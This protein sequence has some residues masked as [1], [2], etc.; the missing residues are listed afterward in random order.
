[1]LDA[2]QGTHITDFIYGLS[3]AGGR[4]LLLF[5]TAGDMLDSY[6]FNS[7]VVDGW[8][9][10]EFVFVVTADDLI[11]SLYRGK[12]TLADALYGEP[13]V[14][15]N[16]VSVDSVVSG[17]KRQLEALSSS[18]L[19]TNK[20]TVAE[21]ELLDSKSRVVLPEDQAVRVLH[22]VP[23][24]V[25]IDIE[26]PR[27]ARGRRRFLT[28]ASLGM[29]LVRSLT[30]ADQDLVYLVWSGTSSRQVHFQRST[31]LNL[32]RVIDVSGQI[33]TINEAV[34]FSSLGKLCLAGSRNGMWEVLLVRTATLATE[35]LYNAYHSKLADCGECTAT[36]SVAQDGLDTYF[37]VRIP[38]GLRLIKANLM[39]NAVVQYDTLRNQVSNDITV[40]AMMLD[41]L[42][43]AGLLFAHLSEDE[44]TVAYKFQMSDLLIFG[45]NKFLTT[46]TAVERVIS[47]TADTS[48]R[49]LFCLTSV[50]TIQVKVVKLNLFALHAFEPTVADTRGGSLIT[51][52]GEGFV[53]LGQT[54]C[55]FGDGISAYVEK[56]V[57]NT[58]SEIICRAPED[59]GGAN[60]CTGQLLEVTL[61]GGSTCTTDSP[62]FSQNALRLLRVPTSTVIT[63]SPSFNVFQ[64][65]TVVTLEGIGFVDSNYLSC[66]WFS[67]ATPSDPPD[68]DAIYAR[69]DQNH[70]L[71]PASSRHSVTYVNSFKI[72]CKQ[73]P[74]TNNQPTSIPAYVE[75]S[76]DGQLYSESQ[77]E[78]AIYGRPAGLQ[79]RE[80][81]VSVRADLESDVEAMTIVTVDEAGHE[82]LRYDQ[83]DARN[84][85]EREVFMRIAN[86]RVDDNSN[87]ASTIT[88]EGDSRRSMTSG[89]VQ[90][91]NIT[92]LRP[93][94]GT[95]DAVFTHIIRG[96]TFNATTALWDS[97]IV[98]EWSVTV[99]ITV[100]SGTAVTLSIAKQPSNESNHA[101]DLPL[102]V[103]PELEFLDSAENVVTNPETSTIGVVAEWQAY[104]WRPLSSNKT[105]NSDSTCPNGR[106]G[107]CTCKPEYLRALNYSWVPSDAEVCYNAV[108][109]SGAQPSFMDKYGK[110]IF[111]DVKLVGFH[112][113]LYKLKFRVT[114]PA[115]LGDTIRPVESHYIHVGRCSPQSTTYAL[116][117][118]EVCKACPNDAICSGTIHIQGK[119][120]FWRATNLTT[121]FY[122]CSGSNCNASV[123]C[124]VSTCPNAC[125]EGYRGV[126]CSVC[127]K[128]YGRSGDT[129][130]PCPK[131]EAVCQP[132]PKKNRSGAYLF[133]RTYG[134]TVDSGL[135][136]D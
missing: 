82:L 73:P 59:S 38:F 107:L 121:T 50:G 97:Y 7:A 105:E 113:I 125:A 128:G 84:P 28:Q 40:T 34:F 117:F 45:T 93:P 5:D 115:E 16:S 109:S 126:Q 122:E 11:Y 110:V 91:S 98:S 135:N 89:L 66:K 47:V 46:G 70:I 49:E 62:S 61:V 92:L 58:G 23:F 69:K 116:E 85:Y 39:T 131:A 3:Y 25:D 12:R 30:D 68:G 29:K 63:A 72:L 56:A 26:L 52:T 24:N 106:P 78:Y 134:K 83:D 112:G 77:V 130:M 133:V 14:S 17:A 19:F 32:I 42:S 104:L 1:M 74:S 88:M 57:Q 114:I 94:T 129:C 37:S 27:V 64:G 60:S 36:L 120:N 132:L 76:L 79:A 81:I 127:E 9:G 20:S 136:C 95:V 13:S 86:L 65:E 99:T 41:E 35:S 108:S 75:V 4:P 100:V 15:G 48:N 101:T 33:D 90:F 6:D 22:S 80:A 8:V 102:T 103:Q 43:N 44:P 51:I 31:T 123:T 21:A 67:A 87:N 55:K 96:Q 18:E 53:N 71:N 124:N 54:C 119:T 2:T 118:S 10:T 111:S